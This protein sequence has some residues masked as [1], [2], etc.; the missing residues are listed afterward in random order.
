VLGLIRQRS[1]FVRGTLHGTM[2]RND[3]YDFSRLG[4]FIERADNTARLLDVKYYVLLPT[5]SGVGSSLDN[6]Q[7]EVILRSL[8]AE[9]AFRSVHGA[10]RS[11]GTIASF[12]ILD[13]RMPRSLA[14]CYGKIGDELDHLYRDYG[15][16]LPC[17]DLADETCGLLA[18]A[19]M[20]SILEEGLH[21]FLQD[22]LGRNARLAGQIE[23]D[24]R[25]T[26]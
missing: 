25:F 16:R 11:P 14:F 24:Y 15:I 6:A 21:Q 9:G 4:T 20:A 23:R 12:L 22:F 5:A 18:R 13:R 8:S 17:H 1:A 19:T 2:L 3:G 26:Q 10:T 7:W